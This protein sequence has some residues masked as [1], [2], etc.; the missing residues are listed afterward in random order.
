MKKFVALFDG[1][2]D[3]E[4]HVRDLGTLVERVTRESGLEAHYRK[5]RTEEDDER[6]ANLA[7]LISAASEFRPDEESP[8]AERS[9]LDVLSAFLESVALVSDAD[10]VDPESGAVTLMTLHTAKGLEFDVVA[11]AGLEEGLLP[12]VRAAMEEE[13]CEEERRLFF[14]GLTRARATCW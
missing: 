2:T 11:I 13:D 9:I 12:H 4:Q 8:G 1:W 6:L 5:S 14:V 10:A 7:E 3:P